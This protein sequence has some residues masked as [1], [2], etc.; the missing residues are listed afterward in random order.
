MEKKLLEGY[1]RGWHVEE[2]LVNHFNDV[3]EEIRQE[4]VED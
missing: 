1:R 2:F 4:M 3:I